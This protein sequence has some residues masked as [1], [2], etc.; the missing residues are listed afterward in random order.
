MQNKM[1]AGYKVQDDL[2]Q[3]WFMATVNGQPVSDTLHDNPRDAVDE[4]AKW[5]ECRLDG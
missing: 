2:V 4:A 3:E 1:V 5:I